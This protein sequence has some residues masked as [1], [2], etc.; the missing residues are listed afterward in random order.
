MSWSE[1]LHVSSHELS[2]V[3]VWC[4][5]ICVE[6][7]LS[8]FLGESSY[9]VISLI[10]SHFEHRNVHSSEN[11]LNDRHGSPDVFRSLFA[12]SLILFVSLVA[13]RRSVWV[14]RHTEVC[15]LLLCHHLV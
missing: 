15:G 14:E 2:I 7:H 13:E 8:G 6:S 1:H 11:V 12:L 9:H 5:H 4:E 10:A 3:L